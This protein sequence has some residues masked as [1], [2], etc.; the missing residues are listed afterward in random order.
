M[1][2]GRADRAAH[3]CQGE[4]AEQDQYDADGELH[5]QTEPW[6]DDN[7]EHDDRH[8]DRRDRDGM[9]DATGGAD[10][11]RARYAA[12]ATDDRRNGDHMVGV[13][14]MPHPDE[15]AE[16]TGK[17]TKFRTAP[18]IARA[19]RWLSPVVLCGVSSQRQFL[20]C[21]SKAASPLSRID[22]FNGRIPSIADL[23]LSLPGPRRV[24]TNPLA[25]TYW[26][27][28]RGCLPRGGRA[29]AA[30]CQARES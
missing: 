7:L 27:L 8:A 19:P 15:E 30:S 23:F 13:G 2:V 24:P 29:K 26:A 28:L 11:R 16:K 5:R 25:F 4:N 9:P 18:V 14:R 21:H 6:R 3:P 12:L 17:D 10:Q 1:G 20:I 22:L